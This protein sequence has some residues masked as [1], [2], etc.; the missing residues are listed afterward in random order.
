MF[1]NRPDFKLETATEGTFTL[2]PADKMLDALRRDSEAMAGMISGP[3]PP[4]DDVMVS[5]ASLD[6]ILNGPG[7]PPSS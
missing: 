2:K 4:F 1:F 3:V 5:I 7:Q 6:E